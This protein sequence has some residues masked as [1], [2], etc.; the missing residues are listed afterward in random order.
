MKR[1]PRPKK[2]PII[3]LLPNAGL[4]GVLRQEESMYSKNHQIDHPVCN[5]ILNHKPDILDD[6]EVPAKTI[7]NAATEDTDYPLSPYAGKPANP[8][9]GPGSTV[10][11]VTPGE[12]DGLQNPNRPGMFLVCLS[13]EEMY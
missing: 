4:P 9:P 2:Q 6:A 10:L 8:A 12:A 3:Y 13:S 7:P 11:P 5:S 1:S